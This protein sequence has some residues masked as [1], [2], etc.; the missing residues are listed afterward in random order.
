MFDNRD[1]RTGETETIIGPTVQVE[2]NF[3]GAGDVVVEGQLSGTLKTQKSLRVG[4][5]ARVKADVEASDVFVS[6]EIRG[7]VKARGRLELTA[8]GK[9]LGN[10]E[11]ATLVVAEGAVLHGKVTMAGKD[12]L[13]L[14][15]LEAER[16][17]TGK[18][19]Q[20]SQD[21]K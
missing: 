7:N 16:P 17:V 14:E 1:K 12:A 6:G 13:P 2:G 8:T 21:G 18:K 15:P 3:Q 9:V 10:I 11:T 20:K 5:Q 19:N 4:E